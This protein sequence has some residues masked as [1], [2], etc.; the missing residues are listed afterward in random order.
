MSAL[1]RRTSSGYV[2]WPYDAGTMNEYTVTDLSSP[3]SSIKAYNAIVSIRKGDQFDVTVAVRENT[4]VKTLVEDSL[5]LQEDESTTVQGKLPKPLK[6]TRKAHCDSAASDSTEDY[7]PIM[8]SSVAFE[9]S[10]PDDLAYFT[11]NTADAGYQD[12]AATGRTRGANAGR[13]CLPSDIK[14]EDEVVGIEFDCW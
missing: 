2:D 11:F 7:D 12:F 3:G 14:K 10:T 6:I 4:V 8:E 5:I 1:Q 13:Y 9:Y